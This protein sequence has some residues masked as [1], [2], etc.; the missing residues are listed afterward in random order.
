MDIMD[1]AR[2]AEEGAARKAERDAADFACRDI[3]QWHSERRNL[4]AARKLL[5]EKG[6]SPARKYCG[7]SGFAAFAKANEAWLE[8]RGACRRALSRIDSSGL[9]EALGGFFAERA[10]LLPAD[11]GFD[12]K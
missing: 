10:G 1:P 3:M 9:M 5:K 6:L 8:R 11:R 12:A 4:K 2:Q 7:F